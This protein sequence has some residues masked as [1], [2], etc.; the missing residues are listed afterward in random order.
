[1]PYVHRYSLGSN[2]KCFSHLCKIINTMG[3]IV[4]VHNYKKC[5]SAAAATHKLG[6]P[7]TVL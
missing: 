7:T 1:M 3:G 4:V 5:N 2:K 6:C